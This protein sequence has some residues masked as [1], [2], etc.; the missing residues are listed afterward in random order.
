MSNPTTHLS[1]HATDND[2]TVTADN[3]SS[4]HDPH[5]VDNHSDAE[6]APPTT[7]T[8]GIADS[9]ATGHFLK[10][11]APVT[12]KQVAI[13]PINITLPDGSKIQSSHTC[14]LDIPWLLDEITSQN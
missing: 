4:A 3:R 6:N 14:N 11:D 1:H 10:N 12:N 13:N 9:G 5:N 8:M 2:I 7:I